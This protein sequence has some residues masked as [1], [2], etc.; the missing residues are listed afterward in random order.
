MDH[1]YRPQR[2]D[3]HASRAD[4]P[5][6]PSRSEQHS[7]LPLVIPAKPYTQ[8]SRTSSLQSYYTLP[9]SFTPPYAP[10]PPNAPGPSNAPTPPSAPTPYHSWP[11]NTSF[12]SYYSADTSP[13]SHLST[14]SSSTQ[15]SNLSFPFS[16]TSINSYKS[17]KN[18]LYPR[19]VH[20]LPVAVAS[21][22]SVSPDVRCI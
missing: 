21:E 16:V 6:G 17:R 12:H 8:P 13:M 2:I 9:Y 15:S 1:S 4:G 7:W 3:A 20:P 22:R 11:S 10:S 18:V 5:S 14:Y 19:R